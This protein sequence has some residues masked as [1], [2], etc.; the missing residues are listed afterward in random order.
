VIEQI[1]QIY[2]KVLLSIDSTQ[3]P[4]NLKVE[5]YPYVG[6]SNRI[7]RRDGAYFVRISDV[8]R[9]APAEF[10][11]ALAQILLRKLFRRRVPAKDLQIYR[12]YLKQTHV[13]EK[14]AENRRE[15]GRKVV[16][17]A[18]GEVYD[19][20]EI[21]L[22]LNQ[23]YFQNALPK[24]VLTW[25]ARE[26]FRILGHHDSAHET[27]AVSKSLD[28]RQ[29]PRFVVEY[30]VYH[31]MLHVKHPTVHHNGRRYNHTPAFRRDEEN[32]AYFEEAE[33]WIEQNL[34]AIKRKA[35]K[36]NSSRKTSG[37]KN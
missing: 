37:K 14:T 11:E 3:N 2:E 22:F 7:R 33:A 28:A 27:I 16:T 17:T 1:T 32:F 6:I 34:A 18:K 26:T 36:G 24:P 35:K 20:D 31:E 21:F 29:V 13:H 8:L 9:D 15:R 23:I 10:H 12:D 19:L 5:F 30:V 4:S 25:S